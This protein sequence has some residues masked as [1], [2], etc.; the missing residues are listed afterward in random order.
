MLSSAT[1]TFAARA[2]ITSSVAVTSSSVVL[3]V[4]RSTCFVTLSVVFHI[5][6]AYVA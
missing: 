2:S 4:A 6:S 5:A 1:M 3:P